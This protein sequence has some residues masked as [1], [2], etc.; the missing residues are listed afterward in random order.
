MIILKN[1]SCVAN[2]VNPYMPP[3]VIAPCLSG[4][5]FGHPKFSDGEVVRTTRI[6]KAD[7]CTITT[8]S[9]SIYLLQGE[10]NSEYLEYLD[11]NN[12]SFNRESPIIIK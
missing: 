9:G 11:K 1:W 4:V 5:V 12:Y 7:G 6:V 8:A 2:G 10:P 3:E